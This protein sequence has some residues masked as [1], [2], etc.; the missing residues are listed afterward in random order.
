MAFIAAGSG[1][2]NSSCR[3]TPSPGAAR[4]AQA[5]PTPR[6]MSRSVW[7]PDRR[8]LTPP[9]HQPLW[10]WRS[11]AVLFSLARGGDGRR[12]HCACCW[13]VRRS[14]GIGSFNTDSNM[15][16]DLIDDIQVWPGN[17]LNMFFTNHFGG[18]YEPGL[19][20]ALGQ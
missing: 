1:Y 9:Q 2:T 18:Y 19:P 12:D 20:C 16:G 8:T 14:A 3:H 17:P 11:G 15:M 5:G 7:R 13:A 10:V 6:S 4:S